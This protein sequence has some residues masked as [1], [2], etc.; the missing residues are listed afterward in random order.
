[1]RDCHTA[2]TE[3]P[4]RVDKPPR[5]RKVVSFN[6]NVHVV[7][8]P[9][10]ASSTH[11]SLADDLPPRYPEGKQTRRR[12]RAVLRLLSRVAGPILQ[13]EQTHYSEVMSAQT[14]CFSAQAEACCGLRLGGTTEVVYDELSPNGKLAHASS[15]KG[16]RE[17]LAGGFDSSRELYNSSDLVVSYERARQ[18]IDHLKADPTRPGVSVRKDTIADDFDYNERR[19][20]DD[21]DT[22]S[23]SDAHPSRDGIDEPEAIGDQLL[24]PG[25]E[26]KDDTPVNSAFNIVPLWQRL[27]RVDELDA[28]L[29][30]SNAAREKAAQLSDTAGGSDKDFQD[31]SDQMSE[32]GGQAAKE[33]DADTTGYSSNT[34]TGLSPPTREEHRVIS[35]GFDG[36]PEATDRNVAVAL[37]PVSEAGCDG[38]DVDGEQDIPAVATI[39]YASPSALDLGTAS[40]PLSVADPASDVDALLA[41]QRSPEQRAPGSAPAEKSKERDCEPL[42]GAREINATVLLSAQNVTQGN[43]S[44]DHSVLSGGSLAEVEMSVSRSSESAIASGMEIRSF[45]PLEKPRKDDV[46]ADGLDPSQ[47]EKL[48]PVRNAL[49]LLPGDGTS[50]TSTFEESNVMHSEGDDSIQ[51]NA[52]SAATA[53]DEGVRDGIVGLDLDPL[54][55]PS[56]DDY[57][58][59]PC[60]PAQS[61][62]AGVFYGTDSPVHDLNSPE[63]DVKGVTGL[64]DYPEYAMVK[65]QGNEDSVFGSEPNTPVLRTASGWNE[66][67]ND[68]DLGDLMREEELPLRHGNFEDRKN[69]QAVPEVLLHD[70][71][72]STPVEPNVEIVDSAPNSRSSSSYSHIFNPRLRDQ[73]AEMP[74]AAVLLST[75]LNVDMS[76]LYAASA[77]RSGSERLSY[78]Q[79]RTAN[80]AIPIVSGENRSAAFNDN[81]EQQSSEHSQQQLANP[82]EGRSSNSLVAWVSS[83]YEDHSQQNEDGNN[84]DTSDVASGAFFT[85]IPGLHPPDPKLPDFQISV[86]RKSF[87]DG[88]RRPV[89]INRG[90]SFAETE[91]RL[92]SS[93]EPSSDFRNFSREHQKQEANQ[94]RLISPQRRRRMSNLETSSNDQ[95]DFSNNPFRS[96]IGRLTSGMNLAKRLVSSH[97]HG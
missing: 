39:M 51:F 55:L 33:T 58:V 54:C 59:A 6:E 70:W 73:Q 82:N 57:S 56:H 36:K 37:T 93:A 15:E 9:N 16:H 50:E 23:L 10:D 53:D 96:V 52:L 65:S 28:M 60:S 25:K 40:D 26:S 12:T 32:T 45:E 92:E 11:S 86:D 1:M 41:I 75:R 69:R 31:A 77:G 91:R 68:F 74:N 64:A 46:E 2:R 85:S 95:D 97:Q 47:Q 83:D 94:R 88:Y 30:L 27:K 87:S 80:N 66:P 19:H 5:A 89:R 38:D 22:L 44:D 43:V 3:T 21:D 34:Q 29:P 8:Y 84:G 62:L 63:T 90:A 20:S 14:S 48:K 13:P 35:G 24:S 78:G 61:P 49:S 79:D 67:F 71:S 7:T 42:Q 18:T 72:G 4:P 81:G 76:K 17:G